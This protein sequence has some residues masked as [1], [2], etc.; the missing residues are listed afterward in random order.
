LALEFEIVY[1]HALRPS[2]RPR[3][4][5]ESAVSLQDMRQLLR[6]ERPEGGTR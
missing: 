4:L 5:P 3:V 6:G 2:A 1:G